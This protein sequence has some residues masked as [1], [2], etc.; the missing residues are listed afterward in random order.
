MTWLNVHAAYDDTHPF[1]AMEMVARCSR[2]ETEL[3]E[4]MQAAERT[5]EYYHLALEDSLRAGR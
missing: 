2:N 3:E 1:E 5:F 4:A